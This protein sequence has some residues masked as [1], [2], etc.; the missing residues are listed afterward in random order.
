MDLPYILHPN[1][2]TYSQTIIDNIFFNY[3]SKEAVC[4]KLIPTISDHLPQVLF[5]PSMFSDNSDT[6]SNIFERSWTNFNQAEFVMD[7]FDKDWSNI[8]NLKHGNV[9]VSMENFVNNMNDLLDKHAPFKKISKY[10]LKF[11]TKPWITAALQKSI[12]IKNSLFKKY[13]RLKSPVKKN[14]VHQQYKYYR[15]RLSTSMKKSKKNYYE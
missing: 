9:N 7:Y 13:I 8:L 4:G 3:V 1:R 6:K 2:V 10:K 5:I 14:E 12:S 15:N 11:K